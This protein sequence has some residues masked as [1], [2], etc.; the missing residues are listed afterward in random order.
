MK[1][2][3]K[4]DF[5]PALDV[6]KWETKK[7]DLTLFENLT[8]FFLSLLRGVATIG[9]KDQNVTFLRGIDVGTR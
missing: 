2:V 1:N 7:R 9:V 5:S 6:F 8:A 3:D 4:I